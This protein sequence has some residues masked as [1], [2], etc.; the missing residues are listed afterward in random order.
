MFV[1]FLLRLSHESPAAS[2]GWVGISAED[3][4][5]MSRRCWGWRAELEIAPPPSTVRRSS[6][7][8]AAV[9]SCPCWDP[10]RV[11]GCTATCREVCLRS[12][13]RR[14]DIFPEPLATSH[15][16]QKVKA[17]VFPIALEVR[18][19]NLDLG[20]FPCYILDLTPSFSPIVHVFTI[21]NHQPHSQCPV[22]MLFCPP[23][24]TKRRLI[25]CRLA[26]LWPRHGG[27]S[28]PGPQLH[29]VGNSK[30]V[31]SIRQAS[32]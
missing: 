7:S 31:G 26:R 24:A 17:L 11:A 29:D 32:D 5:T 22:P 15:R 28:N 30:F 6:K 3:K 9:Q 25:T 8:I 23:V 14:S 4:E 1:N 13:S 21:Q 12:K 18:E 16:V 20:G 2:C 10:L 27:A 19:G